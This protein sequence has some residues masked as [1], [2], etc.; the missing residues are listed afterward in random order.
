MKKPWL[1]VAIPI[2]AVAAVC[3]IMAARFESKIAPNTFVGPVDVG[4]LTKTEAQEKLNKWWADQHG[5]SFA[6]YTKSKAMDLELSVDQAGFGLDSEKDLTNAPMTTVVSSTF[7]S[8]QSA[9]HL[10]LALKWTTGPSPEFS[11]Y[12]SSISGRNSPARVY[13]KAGSF[14]RI[15]EESNYTSDSA[16]LLISLSDA[17]AKSSREVEIPTKIAEARVNAS[18]L[19]KITDVVS[20]FTTKFPVRKKDRNVNIRIAAGKIN[21]WVLMPGDTFSFNQV[22]G[23]RTIQDGYKE[24]PVF[25]NGKHD[26]GV[27]GG[28]CQVSSTLYNASLFADL[29]IVQRHNH[30]MPVAY[31][32]VGRDATVD[33]GSLDL[34]FKNNLTTPIALSSEYEAGKLTF[35]I[36]GKKDP[37]LD[38]KIE[39]S[40]AQTWSGPIKTVMDAKLTVGQKKVLEKGSNGH[41]IRTFRVVYRDGKEVA[42]EPLGRSLYKGG[43]RVVAVG[44]LPTFVSGLPGPSTSTQSPSQ[45]SPAH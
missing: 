11:K 45:S 8:P 32:P 2:C 20:T 17:L 5:K 33:Y 38:I 30:S 44:T 29:Q 28:I 23:R 13:Y 15:P 39:S 41:S 10:P 42:R 16:A 19:N 37:G 36:L 24:A 12:I 40:D 9:T 21:G 3:A 22:V 18:E 34:A 1:F 7:N 27:G 4:N 35:R 14:K 43:E 26:M 25:K 6:F 31:L